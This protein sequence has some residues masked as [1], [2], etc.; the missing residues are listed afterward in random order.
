MTARHLSIERGLLFPEYL[1]YCFHVKGYIS[2][3]H[4]VAI[5]FIEPTGEWEADNWKIDIEEVDERVE[6]IVLPLIS[7]S[8]NSFFEIEGEDIVLED[9]N[10]ITDR[11]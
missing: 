3:T 5:E 1:S 6:N 2:K 10:L 11:F 8:E 4:G 9:L 7:K